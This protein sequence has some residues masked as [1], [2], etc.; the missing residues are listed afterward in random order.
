MAE[1]SGREGDGGELLELFGS[2][3]G[4][5]VQ[6]AGVC[7]AK[8]GQAYGMMSSLIQGLQNWLNVSM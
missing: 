4:G 3:L 7:E 8:G 1:A 5:V 2:C 6:V